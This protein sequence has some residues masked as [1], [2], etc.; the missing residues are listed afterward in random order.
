MKKTITIF[1]MISAL[2][3]A[4]FFGQSQRSNQ[5]LTKTES[6]VRQIEEDPSPEL[7]EKLFLLLLAEIGLK[8]LIIDNPLPIQKVKEVIITKIQPC[9]KESKTKNIITKRSLSKPTPKKPEKQR[10]IL[11][12]NSPFIVKNINKLHKESYTHVMP[13]P[14][15]P[16]VQRFE[17]FAKS[18]DTDTYE[19]VIL[20]QAKHTGKNWQGKVEVR[21]S[22]RYK[23]QIY[24]HTLSGN[25]KSILLANT[26]PKSLLIDL[27]KY[28]IHLNYLRD[29]LHGGEIYMKKNKSSFRPWGKLR[30]ID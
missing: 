26:K 28:L 6:I 9:V 10:K 21:I 24:Q 19:L 3:A 12:A 7:Y 23:G 20:S 18:Y 15:L 5:L 25:N 29:R 13:H 11:R 4:F 8:G 2:V 30:L 16:K 14:N 17:I 1:L 22:S 27:G